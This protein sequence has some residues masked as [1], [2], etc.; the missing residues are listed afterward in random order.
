MLYIRTPPQPPVKPR[1][2]ATPT[3]SLSQRLST[4]RTRKNAV[5]LQARFSTFLNRETTPNKP[6]ERSRGRVFSEPS[7]GID[8]CDKSA[9]LVAAPRRSTSSLDD[10][11]S[12]HA[13]D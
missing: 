13:S 8:D 7:R 2:I 3:S 10:R 11:D 12:W 9:S 4:Y 1:S 6:L 5:S